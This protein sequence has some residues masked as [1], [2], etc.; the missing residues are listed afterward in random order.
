MAAAKNYGFIWKQGSD[1]SE[2][3]LIFCMQPIVEV[4]YLC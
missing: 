4:T 3:M 2:A 1:G